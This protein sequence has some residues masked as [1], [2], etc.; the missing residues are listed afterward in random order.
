MRKLAYTIALMIA[1]SGAAYPDNWP[2]WRGVTGNGVSN[3]SG[4]P[5]T[6][7]ND[8]VLWKASIAGAN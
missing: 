2:Q 1:L 7:T 4:L 6:W 3:E 5:M 8:N